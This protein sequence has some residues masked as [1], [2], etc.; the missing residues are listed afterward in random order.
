MKRHAAFAAFAIIPHPGLAL[1]PAASLTVGRLS[2]RD[3][4]LR[5]VDLLMG[6][7]DTNDELTESNPESSEAVTAMSPFSAAKLLVVDKVSSPLS[8]VDSTIEKYGKPSQR[9]DIQ[10]TVDDRALSN[11]YSPALK[12]SSY[13]AAEVDALLEAVSGTDRGMICEPDQRLQVEKLIEG[14]E[15]RAVDQNALESDLLCQRSE[16]RVTIYKQFLSKF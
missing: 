3:D 11:D 12:E 13:E 8:A 6:R 7:T 10:R 4:V 5:A 9:P 2:E 14:L 15:A 1:V 16:V